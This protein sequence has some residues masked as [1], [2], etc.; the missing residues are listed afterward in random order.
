MNEI[1]KY[2]FWD[3][4]EK[5]FHYPPDLA[6]IGAFFILVHNSKNLLNKDG[7][8]VIQ[9][10]TSLKDKKG[11][12]VYEGDILSSVDNDISGVVRLSKYEDSEG[13]NENEHFGWIIK[14]KNKITGIC[15]YGGTLPDCLD[16]D[17]STVIGN[18]F[19][20]PELL[21]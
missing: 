10:F 3:K 16:S 1:I 11:T 20:N 21:K 14:F 18:I 6:S 5:K 13:W 19:E 9:Q 12:E 2:R 15:Q 7:D 4:V 8:Y 17:E